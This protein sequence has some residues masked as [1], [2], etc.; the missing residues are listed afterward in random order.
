MGSQSVVE[1]ASPSGLRHAGTRILANELRPAAAAVGTP[2]RGNNLVC[3][4]VQGLIGRF[5][6]PL[7]HRREAYPPRRL[8]RAGWGRQDQEQPGTVRLRSLGR[9]PEPVVPDL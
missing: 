2:G 3:H 1:L 5:T 4:L 9:V 6:R 7:E 8:R